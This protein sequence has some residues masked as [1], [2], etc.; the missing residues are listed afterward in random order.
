MDVHQYKEARMTTY[1]APTATLDQVDLYDLLG[2]DS[3]AMDEDGRTIASLRVRNWITEH[4]EDT[5]RSKR[6][7][8]I[9]HLALLGVDCPLAN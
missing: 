1:D 7:F 6:R 8:F 3:D 9:K 2:I 4:G 5:V